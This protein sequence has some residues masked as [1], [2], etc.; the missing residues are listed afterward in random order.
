M[1]FH[2]ALVEVQDD[3]LPVLQGQTVTVALN[4]QRPADVCARYKAD[5]F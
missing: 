1:R 4:G 5:G 3:G 2:G